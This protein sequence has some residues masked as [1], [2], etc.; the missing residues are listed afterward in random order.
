MPP[1]LLRMLMHKFYSPDDSGGMGEGGNNPDPN[2]KGS[3]E[4]NAETEA[5]IQKR[6]KEAQEGQKAELEKQI[7]KEIEEEGKMTDLQKLQKEREKF[8]EEKKHAQEELDKQKVELNVSKVKVIYAKAGLSD[9][10]I[11]MLTKDVTI[12]FSV[13]EKKANEFVKAYNEH[14]EKVKEDLKKG[15]QKS[16]P[17]AKQVDENK[18]SKGNK[19]FKNKSEVVNEKTRNKYFKR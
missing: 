1:Y 16:Q 19:Y 9:K 17:N 3:G 18:E 4:P 13:E 6:I 12:D 10:L 15:I 7:R 2:A 14:I 5:E 8:E 11:D